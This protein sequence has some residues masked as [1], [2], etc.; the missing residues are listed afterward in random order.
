MRANDLDHSVS[1][2]EEFHNLSKAELR[3]AEDKNTKLAIKLEEEKEKSEK[4][5]HALNLMVE[6]HR[7]GLLTGDDDSVEKARKLLEE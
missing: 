7:L 2:M 3:K 1:L 5:W 6:S 4:L